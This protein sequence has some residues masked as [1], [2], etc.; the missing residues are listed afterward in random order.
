MYCPELS[1]PSFAHTPERRP[2]PVYVASSTV[3]SGNR[4][5]AMSLPSLSTLG[6]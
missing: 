2:Q 1:Q 6:T 4:M 5:P 3:N